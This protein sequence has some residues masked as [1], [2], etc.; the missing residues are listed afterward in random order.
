LKRQ[1]SNTV[2]RATERALVLGVNDNNNRFNINANNNINN[3]RPARGMTSHALGRTLFPMKTYTRLWEKLT[4]FD[5]LREAYENAKKRKSGNPSVKVF[6]EHWAFNLAL[7]RLEL[8]TKQYRP[9]PLTRFVL[10]DPKT[11]VIY[12]SQFRD[13]IIHHALVNV[14]QPIYEPQF[15]YD[16]HASRQGK[17]TT[18]ALERY[19][20]FLR[21]ITH[22]GAL[23]TNAR[24]NNQ[25]RGYAL[26]CDIK[27]YFETVDHDMLLGIL[28]RQIKDGDVLWLIKI[29]L[30]HYPTEHPGKGMPLGNWTSQF[31]ANVY[32]NELDQ[33]IKQALRAKYYLRYVDDF[34]I[35]AKSRQELENQLV[36]ISIFVENLRLELH[37]TKC[38]IIPL[39]AGVSFLGFKIYYHYLIVRTRNKRKI[40]MKLDKLLRRYERGTIDYASVLD[41]LEGWNAYALQGDTYRLRQRLYDWT[42]QE[43]RNISTWRRAQQ[44]HSH[45]SSE[46]N[47]F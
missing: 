30:D 16:S 1:C 8:L 4:S 38:K 36:S 29:I 13:R 19:Q 15:I 20:L 18:R 26:K 3:N 5:N 7:L 23:Q 32:L 28:R 12:K 33:Y 40:T 42:T 37:P 14:L 17:G 46:P 35:L 41:T 25:V 9:Q 44:D 31:F 43:L 10:R 39:S 11:R 6:G 22:S 34:I 47:I 45:M 24:N 21:R 2:A 27:H